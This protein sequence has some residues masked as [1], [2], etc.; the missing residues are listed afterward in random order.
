MQRIGKSVIYWKEIY[1]VDSAIHLLNNWDL[2]SKTTDFNCRT[3]RLKA[4]LNYLTAN[5]HQVDSSI[6]SYQTEHNPEN[7]YCSC[8]MQKQKT[9]Q[10]EE[11]KWRKQARLT[12]RAL[13]RLD[14][15]PSE[16]SCQF[17]WDSECASLIWSAFSLLSSPHLWTHVQ[18]F[19]VDLR[20]HPIIPLQVRTDQ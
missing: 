5:P 9:Q 4:D 8:K 3:E 11:R 13:Y 12:E 2:D 1:P 6:Q 7:I 16:A 10:T 19:M 18:K 14:S 15:R 20:I 17:L